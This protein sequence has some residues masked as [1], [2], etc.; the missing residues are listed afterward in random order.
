MSEQKQLYRWKRDDLTVTEFIDAWETLQQ[1]LAWV[2]W[3]APGYAGM[4]QLCTGQAAEW[5]TSCGKRHLPTDAFEM[6]IFSQQ[7]EA[8]WCGPVGGKGKS[9]VL[10]EQKKLGMRL[11][12]FAAL[13][14]IVY[15]DTLEQ[16]YLLWGRGTS[17]KSLLANWSVLAEARIGRLEVPIANLAEGHFAVIRTREYLTMEEDHGNVIIGEERLLEITEA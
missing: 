15:R 11:S 1:P 14:E 4:G 10:S 9:A 6:R 2:F 16:K 12:D 17:Q 5:L 7:G 8:R 13:P 3:Y